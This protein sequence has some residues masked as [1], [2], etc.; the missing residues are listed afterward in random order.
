MILQYF[1]YTRVWE[2]KFDLA[3]EKSKINLE[4]S[5]ESTWQTLSPQ[6]LYQDSA[7]KFCLFWRSKFLSFFC[8]CVFCFFFVCVFF[9]PYTCMGMGD[10]L[11][12]NAE[13]FEQNDNTPS[14]EG[15]L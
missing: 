10:I 9:L 6:C 13:Q 2:C 5:F 1:P 12:N 3:I 14:K 7:L 11:F 15:P 8:V 4:S